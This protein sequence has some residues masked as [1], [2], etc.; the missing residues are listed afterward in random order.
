MHFSFRAIF[1][2]F[3]PKL[4]NTVIIITSIIIVVC[5]LALAIHVI[6]G[7]HKSWRI[8]F[9]EGRIFYV[10]HTTVLASMC[11]FTYPKLDKILLYS[12]I[13]IYSIGLWFPA[14]ILF[15][16]HFIMYHKL[17]KEAQIRTN[18]STMDSTLQMRRMMKTFSVIV[19]A[20]YICMI[21]HSILHTYLTHTVILGKV[22][23]RKLYYT[24]SL[25]F[26]CLQNI[27]SC[28]NPLIYAKIHLK[29]YSALKRVWKYF[30][31]CTS[32][33]CITSQRSGLPSIEMRERTRKTE[34]VNSNDGYQ[35]GVGDTESNNGDSVQNTRL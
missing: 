24:M 29:I 15:T 19:I 9:Q 23:N 4:K 22:M 31:S 30:S 2:P 6:V 21:P 5:S 12:Y 25:T 16:L 27:N 34:Y 8:S 17:K 1:K 10:Q 13:L 18:T 3:K 14:I 26:T 28:L 35:L 32:Q 7:G 11:Y 20:F 33:S